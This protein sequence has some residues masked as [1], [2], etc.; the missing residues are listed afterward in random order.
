MPKK[1]WVT[2]RVSAKKLVR[3]PCLRIRINR[4]G[5]IRF[6]GPKRACNSTVTSS[7]PLGVGT[8]DFQIQQFLVFNPK[9]TLGPPTLSLLDPH[10]S[11]SLSNAVPCGSLSEEMQKQLEL[12]KCIFKHGE[13][14]LN[15]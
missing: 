10:F 8:V 14:F 13:P 4:A 11:A 5:V 1:N 2:F 6:V 7:K 12:L 9:K 15:T 3:A